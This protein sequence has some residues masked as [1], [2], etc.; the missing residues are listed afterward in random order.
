MLR[1]ARPRPLPLSKKVS[2]LSKVKSQPDA[3]RSPASARL[4]P[5]TINSLSD[6]RQFQRVMAEALF[7]PLSA[8]DGLQPRWSDGRATRGVVEEFVKPNDRLTSVERLEIYARSY[9]YR[10]LDCLY[11][12]YPGVRAIIG[13]K[14]FMRLTT[15]FL[16]QFPSA[17]FSL[18][19]LGSRLPQFI[20]D[21]PS[22]TGPRP[23]LA[24][25][26]AWFEW[27]QVVA[28]D[29]PAL[30]PISH[31]DILDAGPQLK[32]ALQP[33]LTIMQAAYP[34][35]DLALA[36]KKHDEALRG[37]ASNA[38]SKL[39][40]KRPGLKKAKTPPSLPRPQ[41]IC[42]AV[43]RQENM[44]YFKRLEPEAFAILTALR[45]GRTLSAA[46]NAA[47]RNANPAIDW[48]SRIRDWFQSWQALGWFCRRPTRGRA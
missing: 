28:F 35:D 6:L 48:A 14:R 29:G 17:S 12:D 24:L 10:V 45:A 23:T 19:N 41:T 3:K 8:T 27:A 26:M 46:C 20:A 21:N 22:F 43:H 11:D 42:V 18:R 36:L 2:P 1:R 47:L 37:E 33:Y 39:K 31:D 30:P 5:A 34:V 40:G 38:V 16:A 44:L 13:V 32:V 7:R 15:A 4:T 25:D 9:W